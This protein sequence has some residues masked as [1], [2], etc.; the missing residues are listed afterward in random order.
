M[1][2]ARLSP[3]VSTF[4]DLHPHLRHLYHNFKKNLLKAHR[5]KN[6][7]KFLKE[8]RNEKIVPK[9][10]LPKKLRNFNN[11]PF[12]KID[13]EVLTATIKKTSVEVK[14]A[15]RN[16]DKATVMLRNSVTV[17]WWCT[18]SDYV[19]SLLRRQNFFDKRNLSAKLESLF[20][21]SLWSKESNPELYENLSSYQL[22]KTEK[23]VLGFGM[24]FAIAKHQVDPIRVAESFKKLEKHKSEGLSLEYIDIARGCVYGLMN[25]KMV[26]NIPRRFE[27]AL[28]NL[29]S[30]NNIHI[31][32]ADKSNKIVIL[33]KD[34]YI[35]KVNE[36]LSD[37]TTYSKLRNDP[38][39]KVNQE[40][41]SKIKN[42]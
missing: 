6:Q 28:K 37:S 36:L 27:C 15:F 1:D 21:N 19:Y 31:M 11:Q 14:S 34:V 18:L 24:K 10:L 40:F 32:K 25:Q 26:T 33:D 29:K 3:L 20:Q 5:L 13:E 2:L 41:N 4:C 9:S 12:S 8:C 39:Q 42:Y 16:C 23:Q 7:L 17:E 35:R 22:N 30:N 38:T